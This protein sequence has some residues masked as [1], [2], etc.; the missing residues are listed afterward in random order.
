MKNNDKMKLCND[1]VYE[2]SVN[3]PT[4][5]TR[6]FIEYQKCIFKRRNKESSK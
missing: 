2:K 5:Q 1:D 4:K 6:R 3:V